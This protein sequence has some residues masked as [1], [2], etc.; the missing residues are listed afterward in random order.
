[1][2]IKRIVFIGNCHKTFFWAKVGIALQNL[3]YQIDWILVNKSQKDEIHRQFPGSNVLYLPLNIENQGNSKDIKINDLV[4]RDRRLQHE[5]EL[6]L[7]YL[8]NIQHPISSFLE[9]GQKSLVIGELTYGYEMVIFRLVNLMEG[10]YWSSPFLTRNPAGKFSFFTNESFSRELEIPYD[11]LNKI[12]PKQNEDLDYI[13]ANQNHVRDMS[14]ANYIFRKFSTFISNK[15]Y[16]KFD[17]TWHSNSRKDKIKKN[18]KWMVN[19]LTYKFVKR[20]FLSELDQSKRYIIFPLHLEPELNIDTCGRYW[21]NQLE[22]ILKIWRQLLPNDVLLVKEHP[23]AIG[24]RGYSW[25][26]ELEAYPNIVVLDEKES[27]IKILEFVEYVFTI[28]GTMGLEAAL[29]GK[30]VICFGGT[31]YDRLDNVKRV[32]IN[33]LLLSKNIDDLYLNYGDEPIKLNHEEFMKLVQV[34]SFDGDPE[35]DLTANPNVY[36]S[37][38]ISLVAGAFDVVCKELV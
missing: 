7:D 33:S 37:N 20:Y 16:D 35:G 36:S 21:E 1:M 30:K 25:F 28:S 23:V 5:R 3:G 8:Q 14:S 2:S 38:N 17:P 32:G 4:Y 6:G 13:H 19:R 27:V 10:Y 34:R 15:D 26:K 24:N 22:T 12:N 29:A 11:S 18:Y 9:N 31:V